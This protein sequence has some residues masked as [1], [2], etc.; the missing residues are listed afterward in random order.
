[1][2]RI[3]IVGGGIAGLATAIFLRRRGVEVAVYERAPAFAPVGAGILLSPNA[4]AVLDAIGLSEGALAAGVP[5]EEFSVT[6]L[7]LEPYQRLSVEWCRERFGHGLVTLRRSDL[8]AVLAAG[9]GDGVVRL[10]KDLTSLEATRDG[11]RLA[12]ADGSSATADQVLGADGLRS[13]VRSSLFGEV[14]LRYSGQTSFRALVPF[15]LPA[16]WARTGIEIW[17]GTFRFGFAS[18][19]PNEVYYF[20]VVVQPPGTSCFSDDARGWISEGLKGFPPIVRELVAATPAEALL[21]TDI[22]DFK[23]IP[24]WSVGPVGLIG[25]AAH[26]ATPNLG[27]GGAQA[28]EDAYYLDACVDEPSGGIDLDRFHRRRRRKTARITSQSYLFG[29]LAHAHRFVGLR[30]LILRATPRSMTL[31]QTASIY[32][33]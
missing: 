21:Q 32:R 7:S 20:C 26:A 4:L 27:Q 13:R 22:Y 19:T 31:R 11:V 29:R 10:G 8:H 3:A 1:M 15:E 23:P 14:P 30:D 18:T 5:L 17:G 24:R 12:F 33:L 6:D 9:L 2:K 25:D 28:L 16:P